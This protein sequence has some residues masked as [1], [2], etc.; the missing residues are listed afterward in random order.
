MLPSRSSLLRESRFALV[1]PLAA[2]VAYLP[3]VVVPYAFMDDYYLLAWRQGL[4]GEF[5][6]TATQFGRPL[7]A[8]FLS[9]AFGFAWDIA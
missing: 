2:V 9:V 7:H 4:E 6:K 1:A 5:W 8:L 3:A